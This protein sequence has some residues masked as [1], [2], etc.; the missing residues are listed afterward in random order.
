MHGTSNIV[1]FKV[2]RF[3]RRRWGQCALFFIN[4]STKKI[5]CNIYG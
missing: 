5:A 3:V 4:S 1:K 2:T